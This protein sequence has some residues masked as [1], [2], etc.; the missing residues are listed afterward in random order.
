MPASR[1]SAVLAAL[2]AALLAAGCGQ[3]KLNAASVE[4]QIQK[5]IE[6]KTRADVRAVACPKDRPVK[7]GDVFSC[8]VTLATA[9]R[10]PSGHPGR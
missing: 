1:L 10:R 6:E 5:G 3:K 7:Q 4:T 8:T 9:S 2:G